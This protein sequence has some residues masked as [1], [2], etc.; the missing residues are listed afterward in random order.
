MF[1]EPVE[2]MI[3]QNIFTYYLYAI[4]L[5]QREGFSVYNKIYEFEYRLFNQNCKMTMTSVSGHLLN[6]DFVGQYKKWF[7]LSILYKVFWF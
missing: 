3:S 7:V 6:Q 2:F 1:H 4:F 5:F